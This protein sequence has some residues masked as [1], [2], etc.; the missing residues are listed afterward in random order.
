MSKSGSGFQKSQQSRSQA[1]SSS[2]LESSESASNFDA[3]STQ[4]GAI[5][6]GGA[7]S[8]IIFYTNKNNNL[9]LKRSKSI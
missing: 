3:F 2:S 6:V 5:G 7:H 4:G 8:G 1:S 9:N